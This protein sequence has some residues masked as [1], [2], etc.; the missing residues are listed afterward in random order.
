MVSEYTLQDQQYNRKR[1]KC[2]MFP[3]PMQ[4]FIHGQWWAMPLM[5]RE[6]MRQ[7]WELGGL[8]LLQRVQ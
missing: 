3:R 7:W 8:K 2:F 1:R 4:L 6:H 5:Q